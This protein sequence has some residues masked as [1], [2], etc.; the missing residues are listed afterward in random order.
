MSYLTLS[1]LACI[2][3]QCTIFF[4]P[5]EA[6]GLLCAPGTGW[7]LPQLSF[8]CGSA[9]FHFFKSALNLSLCC[10][11]PACLVSPQTAVWACALWSLCQ[12]KRCSTL[13]EHVVSFAPGVVSDWEKAAFLSVLAS[14][15]TVFS[16]LSKQ[17]V[18]SLTISKPT[19]CRW[20]KKN[21]SVGSFLFSFWYTDFIY[22]RSSYL[23]YL[24]ELTSAWK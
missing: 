22:P 16:K 17:P 6:C 10:R 12:Q 3:V 4:G 2:L 5:S 19:M 14:N 20:R 24:L 7:S 8:R 23:Y 9:L 11:A 21:P 1:Y 18:P 15:N 13:R